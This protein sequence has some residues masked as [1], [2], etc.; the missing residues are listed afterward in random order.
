MIKQ[1]NTYHL[2]CFGKPEK[3]QVTSSAKFIPREALFPYA[4]GGNHT[5]G[6]NE[7]SDLILTVHKATCLCKA[8]WAGVGKNDVYVQAYHYPKGGQLDLRK[9]LPKPQ[10]PLQFQKMCRVWPS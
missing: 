2:T 7:L 1:M 8:G 5:N 9:Q 6:S 3:G 10:M 4:S